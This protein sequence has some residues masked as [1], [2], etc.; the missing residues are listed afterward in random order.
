MDSGAVYAFDPGV[1]SGEASGMVGVAS[2]VV[3][4]AFVVSAGLLL[5]HAASEMANR[6]LRRRI[7]NLVEAFF[8]RYTSFLWT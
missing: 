5:S 6:R 8:I 7:K 4:G 1:D 3:P 2:G